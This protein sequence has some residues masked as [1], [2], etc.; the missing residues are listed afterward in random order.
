MTTLMEN[1][2]SNRYRVLGRPGL[3]N[4]ITT[5][6]ENQIRFQDGRISNKLDFTF[7]Q[8]QLGGVKF[9]FMESRTMAELALDDLIF[10]DFERRGP[11]DALIEVRYIPGFK[12]HF[13]DARPYNDSSE[14]R[15]EIVAWTGLKV[16][17]KD[18]HMLMEN[19][20]YLK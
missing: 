12:P 16:A 9:D 2:E 4:F 3:V 13:R 11:E 17:D 18:R 14:K 19:V 20:G 6:F 8:I 7:S 10:L 5:F 15:E 1:G